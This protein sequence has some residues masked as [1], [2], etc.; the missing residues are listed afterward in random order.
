MFQEDL[1]FCEAAELISGVLFI[2]SLAENEALIVRGSR[3]AFSSVS[4][5]VSATSSVSS[6]LALQVRDCSVFLKLICSFH[7]LG[8]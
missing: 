3:R 4:Q 8:I 7:S 1:W 6:G 2:E 5:S